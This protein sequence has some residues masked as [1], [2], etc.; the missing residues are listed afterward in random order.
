MITFKAV[1]DSELRPGREDVITAASYIDHDSGTP[2]HLQAAMGFHDYVELTDVWDHHHSRY[3]FTIGDLSAAEAAMFL[4]AQ[5]STFINR[6]ISG[7]RERDKLGCYIEISACATAEQKLHKTVE[8][9]EIE[10]M[11]K[12]GFWAGGA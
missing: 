9:L 7:L 12:E 3:Y 10:K 11:V 8:S 2:I 4:A 5:D 6:V 1:I